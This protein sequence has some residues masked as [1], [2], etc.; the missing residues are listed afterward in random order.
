MRYNDEALHMN[1]LD[2]IAQVT[3]NFLVLQAKIPCGTMCKCVG[4]KNYDTESK[5]LMSLA[6]AADLRHSQAA[7]GNH[8]LPYHELQQPVQSQ[9]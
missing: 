6:D 5:S 1:P 4:C 9:P 7:T 2:P 8:R 3:Y